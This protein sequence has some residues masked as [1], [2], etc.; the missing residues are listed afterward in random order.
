ML[1]IAKVGHVPRANGNGP[2]VRYEGAR[3]LAAL[4]VELVSERS[5][6]LLDD[7]TMDRP[8]GWVFFYQSK[9]FIETGERMA[10]LVGNAPIIVNRFTNEIRL[11]GTARPIEHYL[12]EYEASL[13][14]AQML[15]TPERRQ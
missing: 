13:P 7:M 10:Q 9:R 2:G 11:T 1:A 6:A 15:A 4:W 8:Y 5:A 14:P 12:A 3:A